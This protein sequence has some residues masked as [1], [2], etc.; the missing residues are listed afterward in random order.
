MKKLGL[1]EIRELYLQFFE[2]KGHLRLPSFS[3]VPRNDPSILLINAGMTPLKPYFTG[4]EKPPRT[5]VTTCQKC[6]RTPDIENVGKT[7]RHGTFF[8]M[9]GNFSFGDYFKK[10]AIPWAWEFVTKVMEIPE[11]RLYVSIYQDDDEAFEIWHKDVGL[12]ADR[13][14]R[15]G[16][17]DNFWEHGTGPCGPC[18]E[19]YYDRGPEKGCGKPDCKVGC[20]CDRYIEFWNLVFTQFNKEE[21]GSYS[22]LE[23]K[24]I[25]TGMG[26]ERLAVIMQDVDNLFEVDTV[27]NILD[28]VCQKAGVKY[29]AGASVAGKGNSSQNATDVSIRVI[30]DHIR[31]TTMMVCDGILPSNEGRG[32]VLRRL[33][34]RAARHGRLLGIEGPFLH[35]VARVV[36]RESG[37][38][39]PELVEKEEYICK[40]I[41]IEEER[42]AATID[43][44]I[45]ILNEFIEQLKAEGSSVMP[46]SMA[47]KL[48]DTYGFPLD[49]TKEIA[50]EAGLTVD[51]EGFMAEMGEQKKK[52]REALKNKETSAWGQ[53]LAAGFDKDLKTEFVG[54]ERYSC[55][56]RILYIIS[57]GE[58]TENAQQGDEV[59]IVL[60]RT[61]FY[62]ESGGQ[63]ADTGTITA[64]NGKVRVTGCTKTG[65]GVYLHNCVVEEGI[66]EKGSDVT[67][68]I[69]VERR[70]ST[71]R[72]HTA[73]HLLQKA[74]RNVLGDHVTQAGSLVEPD[75]LRFDFH[76][77][78]A[79]TKEELK[80]VEDE[81]NAKILED[82]EV[83]V[84]EMPIDEARSLGAM[85]LFGEKYGNVVRVVRAGDYSIELCG[86]THLR[87]TAQAGLIKILGESGV[88]AGVRRIE[89]LTG[90][91]ALKYYH[92]K[93]EQLNSIAAALKTT[94]QE[95]LR[96]VET[97]SA[98]LKAAQ[99]EIEQLKD[100]LVSSSFDEVLGKAV[101]IDGIKVVTARFD[102]LDM[103]ALRNT[104]ESLRSKA[105]TSVVVLASAFG[106][107]VS[108]VAMASKDAVERGAHC[109]NI[110]REAAKAAG[111]GGGGRPD[112]AQAG[113]KDAAKIDEALKCAVDAVRA[114]IK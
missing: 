81:V 16:K 20:D 32:Y 66:I 41:K 12:P 25:D 82:L 19:I 62:A 26:L 37:Q 88:A 72:N 49:L 44:G 100:K 104:C 55:Q 86:G 47:F 96:R 95:S 58:Q 73:T 71:A 40:V 13:I 83:N 50:G 107:K 69:D 93:E 77:F 51:E 112:M 70:L 48:H 89:A 99:K 110:V 63:V 7:A 56:S 8:E 79:M 68:S 1:N 14:Y 59:T 42:F 67:A 84:Q 113:G 98:E 57:D 91:S 54:Y 106:G 76:H 111:G 114:Q 6:I 22:K 80:R 17:A 108:F 102:Q 90:V 11:D 78:S 74:L 30:T 64:R 23:K 60:D 39:Y 34:R 29:G 10:E 46:G 3:L 28:Y 94:P 45:A 61:P 65:E 103:D 53:D 4:A 97:I 5:R 2:S 109:G 33:L 105:G 87:S 24:N 101:D 92:E 18:S 36:V 43:Q 85:A 27:R 15:M 31:S 52:A 21:D 35:D 9:L 38:A 75:R